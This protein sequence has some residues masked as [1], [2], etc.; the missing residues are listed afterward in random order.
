[1][2]GN[3]YF[4][5]GHFGPAYF[6]P[7]V[8]NGGRGYYGKNEPKTLEEKQ[9]EL[10]EEIKQP[11]R[12]EIVTLDREVTTNRDLAEKNLLDDIERK[13]EKFNVEDDIALMLA[14]IEATQ[15]DY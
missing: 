11:V 2:F 15:D 10:I 3:H 1:M 12:T 6:G 5:V 14:I 7:L 4:G 8:P 9:Y 13:I